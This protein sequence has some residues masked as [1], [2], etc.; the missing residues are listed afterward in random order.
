MDLLTFLLRVGKARCLPVSCGG[1][2][3]GGLLGGTDLESRGAQRGG[4]EGRAWLAVQGVHSAHRPVHVRPARGALWW[5]PY[6][7]SALGA[8]PHSHRPTEGDSAV[9]VTL[10]RTPRL[11]Q[12]SDLPQSDRWEVA[13]ARTLSPVLRR[14]HS[15]FSKPRGRPQTRSPRSPTASGRAAAGPGALGPPRPRP[16]PGVLGEERGHERGTRGGAGGCAGPSGARGSAAVV[17]PEALRDLLTAQRAR[18]QRLAAL[19]TAAH[20]AAVEEDHLGLRRDRG[21]GWVLPRPVPGDGAT[22]PPGP[23]VVLYLKDLRPQLSHAI[24]TAQ[25]SL[26]TPYLPAPPAP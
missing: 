7:G 23:L 18:A 3:G 25:K 21:S 24:R 8:L 2:W 10:M 26:P 14:G 19:V 20:V 4:R 5:P 6:S 9:R 22:E 12:G 17:E 13:A 11:P 15:C 1:G 16:R